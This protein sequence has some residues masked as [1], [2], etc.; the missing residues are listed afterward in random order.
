MNENTMASVPQSTG[1]VKFGQKSV[2]KEKVYTKTDLIFTFVYAALGY[3]YVRLFVFGGE[4]DFGAALAF[5]I[6]AYSGAVL[7][8]TKLKGAHPSRETFFWLA[9][10]VSVLFFRTKPYFRLFSRMALASYF[11]VCA[12]GGLCSGSTSA[13][14]IADGI[15]CLMLYPF[16]NFFIGFRSRFY[17]LVH[18]KKK[19][20]KKNILPLAAGIVMAI[21]ALAVVMPLLMKADKN[22]MAGL[23]AVVSSVIDMFFGKADL[24]SV[25][26]NLIFSIPVFCYLYS[27][28]YTACHRDTP[29]ILDSSGARKS[30]DS[31]KIVPA[32]SAKIMLYSLCCVY[33]LFI[34][35]QADYLLGVFAGRLYPGMTYARYARSGFFELCRVGAVNIFMLAAAFAMIKKGRDKEIKIPALALCVLSLLLLSTAAAKMIMYISAY[36]L[37][38][39]RIISTVFLLWMALVFTL[40]A[41]RLKKQF[42]LTKAAVMAGAVMYC[43]LFC[44]DLYSISRSYNMI[45]GF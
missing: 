13:F 22:F 43:A 4:T 5:Y 40:C 31:L 1:K 30:A 12:A 25:Y 17:F 23:P 44:L 42:N 14:I 8:Y 39:K 18:R 27:L 26:V 2:Q 34:L 21:G 10:L 11:T 3:L 41:V 20:V 16:S 19:S 15:N 38:E 37:T 24:F 45:F 29:G 6:A 36:G 28:V 33:T 7:S 9:L 35:M 32:L